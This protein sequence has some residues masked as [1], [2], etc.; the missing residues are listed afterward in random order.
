MS[1]I[2]G[3]DN[4]LWLE[5]NVPYFTETDQND[6]KDTNPFYKLPFIPGGIALSNRS[7]PEF[8]IL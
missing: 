7:L 6:T 8:S 2:K 3:I 4:A 5:R 1:K